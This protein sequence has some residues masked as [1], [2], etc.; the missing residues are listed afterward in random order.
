MLCIKQSDSR[1]PKASGRLVTT[2]ER[3]NEYFYLMNASQQIMKSVE[4]RHLTEFCDAKWDLFQ[5]DVSQVSFHFAYC[6]PIFS[7]NAVMVRVT[8]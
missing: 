1:H 4:K 8:A 7:K 2:S 3:L 5:N 6:N